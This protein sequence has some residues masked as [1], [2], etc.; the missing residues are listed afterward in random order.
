ML[1][2][3]PLL[4]GL[5]VPLV[6]LLLFGCTGLVPKSEPPRYP[7]AERDA[8]ID[9]PVTDAERC[10]LT[11]PLLDRSH[12]AAHK[13][14]NFLTIIDSGDEALVLLVHLIRAAR[15]SID[16]QTFIWADDAVGY[17][18]FRELLGAARR[19][20]RVRI[21]A[22]QMFSTQP[23]DILAFIA[24][25]HQ[26]LS[27]KLYNP[28]G[29]RGDTMLVDYIMQSPLDFDNVN[30]RM[31][32]K[33]FL[34]DGVA[35]TTGGRNF[36]KRY[37]N[38]SG[39]YNYLDRDVLALGAVVG[40]MQA[41]FDAYWQHPLSVDIDQLTDVHQRL[42]VDNVQQ[43]VPAPETGGLD[44]YTDTFDQ[45]ADP[46]VVQGMF[47]DTAYEVDDAT[48]VSDRPGKGAAGDTDDPPETL[49]PM[50]D[51]IK[52]ARQSLVVQSPYFVLT[53]PMFDALASLRKQR[54]DLRFIISTNSL[55]S[56]D[57]YY[58]YA[59]SFKR[60]KSYVKQLG[61]LIYE[62]KPRPEDLAVW[63]PDYAALEQVQQA[64]S[65]T[66]R[67]GSETGRADP[68]PLTVAGLRV[69]IHQK[70]IV[71]DDTL[72]AIGSHNLDPRST[73][74]N[75]EAMLMVRDRPFALALRER[76]VRATRPG[77]AWVVAR[78]QQ[79]PVLGQ[80]SGVFG[81]I[82]RALPFFDIWPFRYTSSFELKAGASPLLP[83]EPGFY[84][85]Y[86]DVGQFPGVGLSPKEIATRLISAFGGFAEPQM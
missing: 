83:G 53:G 9:C 27:L 49:D 21:I 60:K 8:Q 28:V 62:L 48:F 22:D 43:V 42:F 74:I 14:R 35:G 13:D 67:A 79:V 47:L 25:A 46:G 3:R 44:E 12:Q 58:V 11:S 41:S 32:N 75:T 23:V 71:I 72:A 86:E 36:T 33:V 15:Q 73:H 1:N 81:T 40:E 38:R 24:T 5:W 59:L 20:V 85:R 57:A 34:V 50:L 16:I 7:R 78:Q 26:N 29:G 80:I 45:A 84:E 64:T 6:V 68:L 76:I 31:H 66:P 2:N 18:V 52:S 70:S 65:T 17:L 54:P 61:F 51:A 63:V 55:A 39:V 10:A 30:S 69:G 82:S 56:T 77:N 19:G 37:Y 4:T